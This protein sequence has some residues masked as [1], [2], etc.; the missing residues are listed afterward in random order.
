[1]ITERIRSA[2]SAF[3]WYERCPLK[4]IDYYELRA[5]GKTRTC[6]KSGSLKTMT[7]MTTNAW[8]DS[9]RKL[10][11]T[12]LLMLDE[13]HNVTSGT[14]AVMLQTPKE[15]LVRVTA[16]P[17]DDG[18]PLDLTTP[19]RSIIRFKFWDIRDVEEDFESNGGTHLMIYP[20]VSEVAQN[21]AY[22]EARYPGKTIMATGDSICDKKDRLSFKQL[23]SRSMEDCFIVAT[24]VLQESVTLG[25]TRVWDTGSRVRPFTDVAS[26]LISDKPE[27]CDWTPDKL[28]VSATWSEI[29]QVC[30]RVGRIPRSEGGIATI[31]FREGMPPRRG[32]Y[33]GERRDRVPV[34]G[35]YVTDQRIAEF[36]KYKQAIIRKISSGECTSYEIKIRRAL[37]Y[38]EVKAPLRDVAQEKNFY[39]QAM[40]A[41]ERLQESEG[42]AI[43]VSE[44]APVSV[45]LPVLKWVFG[46]T[47]VVHDEVELVAPKPRSYAKSHGNLF[48]QL[49]KVGMQVGEIGPMEAQKMVKAARRVRYDKSNDQGY[50]FLK[51]F[52]KPTRLRIQK[53][54][55]PNMPLHEV[56]R[57][58]RIRVDQ[59]LKFV[60]RNVAHVIKADRYA[61]ALDQLSYLAEIGK[62]V[63][64]GVDEPEQVESLQDSIDENDEEFDHGMWDDDEGLEVGGDGDCWKQMFPPARRPH[65]EGERPIL[66]QHMLG[67]MDR[68]LRQWASVF[69]E[70]SDHKY[71]YV[72]AVD[73]PELHMHLVWQATKRLHLISVSEIPSEKTIPWSRVYEALD[74]YRKG[75]S[76]IM[77]IMADDIE[78]MNVQEIQTPINE[79]ELGDKTG[80][81][82]NAI[83]S[84]VSPLTQEAI[85]G[86]M[87]SEIVDE[88]GRM[89]QI[90][91]YRIHDENVEYFNT[92]GIPHMRES[93]RTHSHPVHYAIRMNKL[94]NVLPSYM[95][96]ET[97]VVNMK[98]S[99]AALLRKRTGKVV[100]EKTVL[101]AAKDFAR[102]GRT[103]AEQPF[104]LGGITTP[105]VVLDQLA[106]YCTAGDIIK[107]FQKNPSVMMVIAG[108]EFPIPAL[109]SSAS[110]L[111]TLWQHRVENGILKYKCEEDESEPY[112]QPFDPSLLLAKTLSSKDKETILYCQVVHSH[113]NSHTQIISRIPIGTD[114]YLSVQMHDF[115][116]LMPVHRNQYLC[117]LVPRNL[118]NSMIDY[119]QS[120]PG[121]KPT[122]RR[123]KLRTLLDPSKFWIDEV[124]KEELIT[125]VD[126]VVTHSGSLRESTSKYYDS[127]SGKFSYNTVGRFKKW[128]DSG[129][130]R[131]YIRRWRKLIS[132]EH[133]LKMIPLVHLEE[134]GTSKGSLVDF[135]WQV[136]REHAVSFWETFKRLIKKNLDPVQYEA[137]E[138]QRDWLSDP[139]EVGKNLKFLTVNHRN[140]SRYTKEEMA[141]A[142]GDA[143]RQM[144]GVKRKQRLVKTPPVLNL[145]RRKTYGPVPEVW[146]E[147]PLLENWDPEFT[148]EA[149]VPEV[150]G[151]EYEGD[152]EVEAV[153]IDQGAWYYETADDNMSTDTESV[154]QMDTATEVMRDDPEMEQKMADD[155]GIV[156]EAEM[157][158]NYSFPVPG[159]AEEVTITPDEHN[160]SYAINH[161]RYEVIASQAK[162]NYEP[163]FTGLG[164][165]AWWDQKY[166]TSTGKRFNSVPYWPPVSKKLH[167]PKQDCLLKSFCSVYRALHGRSISTGAVW[168]LITTMFPANLLD[169][170]MEE[171]LTDEVYDGLCVHWNFWVTLKTEEGDKQIGVREGRAVEIVH[172]DKHFFNF[173]GIA[174]LTIS[175]QIEPYDTV[176]PMATE[177]V[178]ELK[179]NPLIT[180]VPYTPETEPADRYLF[181]LIDKRVGTFRDNPVNEER[182]KAWDKTMKMTIEAEKLNPKE[183][184]IAVVVGDPGCGKSM[185]VA[186]VLRNKKYHVEGVFQVVLPIS[187]VRDDW[188]DKL[189]MRKKHGVANR[190]SNSSLCCTFEYA[191][192]RT[193]SGH[194]AIFD[195]DKFPTGYISL[196]CYL[197]PN[198]KYIIFLG[199]IFQGKWHDAGGKAERLN[200][201]EGEME[202]YVK[203]A[204]KYIIGSDRFSKAVGSVVATP[205][206]RKAQYSGIRFAS[207]M[208]T[209]W[210]DL[211]EIY[212]GV[213]DNLLKEWWADHAALEASNA[214][215]DTAAIL[216]QNDTM[217][218]SSSQGLTKK[219]VLLHLN[220]TVARLVGMDTLWVA[221]SR[222]QRV[223]IYTSFVNSGGTAALLA[224]KPAIRTLM[225][226]AGRTG[227]GRSAVPDPT[228]VI[229]FRRLQGGLNPNWKIVLAFPIAECEN[230]EEVK[231]FF[232]PLYGYIDKG[233]LVKFGG[234]TVY[235]DIDHNDAGH[236]GNPFVATKRRGYPVAKIREISAPKEGYPL[237]K[238]KTKLPKGDKAQYIEYVQAQVPDRFSRE[239]WTDEYGYSLQA[240]EGWRLRRDWV[241][242]RDKAVDENI[243]AGDRRP[244]YIIKRAFMKYARELPDS[245]NP[246][247]FST[248]MLNWGLDQH[249][250]DQTSYVMMLVERVRRGS[251]ESNVAEYELE[252]Q[253][254]DYMWTRWC[255]YAK[256]LRRVPLD[257][258]RY[259][260]A[261]AVFTARRA[262]RSEAMK[263]MGLA[264]ADPDFRRYIVGKTQ[265]K[266]KSTEIKDASA[267]QTT[268]TMDDEYLFE[269][270]GVGVYLL[271]CILNNL[272][273]YIYLHAKKT[274]GD[275]AQFVQEHYVNDTYWESDLK[276]QEQSMRGGALQ[277][278]LRMMEHFSIPNA[279]IRYF[280]QMKL[281][282]KVGRM[283]L[284]LQTA[285]GEIFTYIMNSIGNGARISAKYDLRP[286]DAIMITGDD[287]LANRELK[288]SH[289][290][291]AWQRFDHATEKSAYSTER[292]TFA[293]YVVK[294]GFIFKNPELMLR[295]ML[296]ANEMGKIDDVIRGYFLDWLTIYT[297]SDHLFKLLT[298]KEMEA[299]NI[300]SDM[301]F[302]ARRKLK[303]NAKF[304]WD[305]VV[306]IDIDNMRT[307]LYEPLHAVP[308]ILESLET[309]YTSENL[310][311]EVEDL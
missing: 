176:H 229:D 37:E 188:S 43:T 310:L 101:R 49:P 233:K 134:N 93:P 116:E 305:K 21:Y 123:A 296:I 253:F 278:M 5:G 227:R 254:G 251:Y 102:F 186:S 38:L 266:L 137:L 168:A 100:Q 235:R 172:K 193:S 157:V 60:S 18:I 240:P 118:Y 159:I 70:E 129:F 309:P 238:L 205:T 99:H 145:G 291:A 215:V 105:C 219:L 270:G 198:V 3:E 248:N 119:A 75:D 44:N 163:K 170:Y 256:W 169:G 282:T 237:S 56:M 285:S 122:E 9:K 267:L 112:E 299:H 293:S 7:I 104:E 143:V 279:K 175:D 25:V 40:F 213:A 62:R 28:I 23:E 300:L 79:I 294:G 260:E 161:Q 292:G 95:Q 224:A 295:K 35:P 61:N 230:W 203:Y 275:T 77:C 114:D 245:E 144:Y 287:S 58:G 86:A 183:R 85:D 221:L 177:L 204:T 197:K 284:A 52:N 121:L 187:T 272:P 206:R 202:R 191:L 83:K 80:A 46:T 195:E 124:T 152:P 2:E 199:D 156:E 84:V 115:I 32:F 120:M 258:E 87:Q 276:Q 140:V 166:P 242:I 228:K 261:Q 17:P 222:A 132:A 244:K 286:G 243:R 42:E 16:T 302:N 306:G 255:G 171:G 234:L 180:F 241:K 135:K 29:G 297:L 247:K 257:A 63:I 133:P 78:F 249:N 196:F 158:V 211:R 91:P 130:K 225:E 76:T 141:M 131:K 94:L 184:F 10:K 4:G 250:Y 128:I 98:A 73:V 67:Y 290:W 110:P 8:V 31:A 12:E 265:V 271:D 194:V 212:P 226:Y 218:M 181:H 59:R 74:N 11:R 92:L 97:T 147:D 136:P 231:N 259:E 207:H 151:L 71:K 178:R 88:I 26:R 57:L 273:S 190:P 281:N 153:H 127:F 239:M 307:D 82:S 192:A 174:P 139:S 142:W 220:I 311:Y 155:E 283:V 24:D 304:G 47:E 160:E 201:I 68:A 1:M 269:L 108:H 167:Y 200:A 64:V 90:C 22:L 89:K 298:E 288:I 30:G 66:L 214:A 36:H 216:N 19:L 13:A 236:S 179:N 165:Q 274:F 39:V 149:V 246:L 107:L 125:V 111:P 65:L 146:V 280:E 20:T 301:I 51:L 50:C 208:P 55:Q 103:L 126:T 6:G 15:Q 252:K 268:L 185:P 209:Q 308:E 217:T 33:V 69:R 164:P 138:G 289:D 162:I 182:L 117:D 54:V 81:L 72:N 53:H 262:A 210:T 41:N 263:K 45:E 27:D 173:D 264:R 96:M 113:L 150:D 48:K 232:P 189:D 34:Q 303:V 14:I 148:W 109:F 223:V 154:V 106:H 277:M